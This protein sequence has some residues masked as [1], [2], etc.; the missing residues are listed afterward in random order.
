MRESNGNA[1]I[2][3]IPLPSNSNLPISALAAC[4]NQVTN[5]YKFYWFLAILRHVEKGGAQIITLDALFAHMIASAW[6]P[7]NYFR[8][9]FG[10]QDQLSSI[11]D[12][13]AMQANLP[14]DAPYASVRASAQAH[15][16]QNDEAGKAVREL[17]KF[18]PYRFLRPF[19]SQSLR[20]VKD[21]EI[22]RRIPPLAAQAFQTSQPCLYRFA[23]PPVSAIELHP[24][25]FAYLKQHIGILQGFCLWHLVNYLQKNNP[26]VPNVVGKL[27]EPETRNLRTARDFWNFVLQH[28]GGFNCIYSNQPISSK[29]LSIDHFLPWRFVTH[30]LLWNLIPA[31]KTV[32]S[33][34]SDNLP[35]T[36]YLPLFAQAQYQAVQIVCNSPK[37]NKLL[38]D[39]I[40]LFKVSSVADLRQINAPQF[41]TILDSAIAP[42]LQI[43]A[44]MGFSTG[45]KYP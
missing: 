36:R 41:C 3:P 40:L 10:K 32:N 34:K 14:M 11:A 31:L 37:A 39:Y 17:Q 42:Q 22:N 8:L 26:N 29:N 27:F 15:L 19:F 5:S 16:K 21:W 18:V 33:S 1:R 35:D 23:D 24:E 13:L 20:G 43:A 28:T 7:I 2:A 30:D 4:F 9:S 45:W 38:E 25:W 12:T 6:Y 44:N